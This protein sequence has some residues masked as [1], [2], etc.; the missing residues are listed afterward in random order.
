MSIGINLLH[1]ESAK[2]FDDIAAVSNSLFCSPL[3]EKI[4]FL[5]LY[6]CGG[7]SI[8]QA[9]KTCYYDWRSLVKRNIFHLDRGAARKAARTSL[10]RNSL[11]SY[12]RLQ[13]YLLMYYMNQEHISY[14]AG[15]FNFSELAH[16]YFSDKYSF[17]TVLRNPVK[18][19]ISAYFYMRYKQNSVNMEL[20]DYLKTPEALKCGSLYIKH[21]GDL[22]QREDYTSEAAINQTK[23]NL[24]KFSIVGCLEYEEDFLNRFED[25]FGKRL[26]IR[27]FN[28][29]PKSETDRNSIISKEI[30]E[31][32]KTICRPDIEIYQYAV[33]NFVKTKY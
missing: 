9:I 3:K 14:I 29:G 20:K 21:L 31:E 7:S 13:E 1:D 33:E 24:H 5:H 15:H 6:K 19:F 23:E 28:R 10:T 4:F 26:K 25:R 18:R 12:E 8:S 16:Q 27:E 30:E 22:N 32:I 11:I 2:L 17:I